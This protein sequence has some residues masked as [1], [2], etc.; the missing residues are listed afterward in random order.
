MSAFPQY[1]LVI[2]YGSLCRYDRTNGDKPFAGAPGE[3]FLHRTVDVLA[4]H[5]VPIETRV[6]G[7]PAMSLPYPTNARVLL[8]GDEA[9]A[10]ASPGDINMNKHRGYALTVQSPVTLARHAALATYHPI[11]CWDFSSADEAFSLGDA[12][13]DEDEDEDGGSESKDVAVTKRGNYFAWALHDFWKLVMRAA[14]NWNYDPLPTPSFFDGTMEEITRWLNSIPRNAVVTLDIECRPQD[15][16]LD[17]IGLRCNGRTYVLPWYFHD[18][19]LA[20]KTRAEAGAM[21]RALA[22]L[23]LRDDVTFVG[24]NLSFDF[25]VLAVELGLPLP[26]RLYDTMIAMHR[27][28]PLLEKSLSHAISYFLVTPR[29]HKADI[30]PNVSA[31]NFARLRQYNSEDLVRTEQLRAAQLASARNHPDKLL[32]IE[33]GNELLH[34]TLMMSL[35]GIPT[36]KAQIEKVR[37]EHLARADFARRC[38]A[39]LTGQPDFN[40]ASPDQVAHL[41]YDILHYPILELTK[42]NQPATGA[43]ALYKLQIEQPNPLIPLIIEHREAKKAASSLEF[44]RLRLPSLNNPVPKDETNTNPQAHAK[45]SPV[46]DI[47]FTGGLQIV[48]RA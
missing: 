19:R 6:V 11:D 38:C 29:N 2:I 30:C 33:Q 12:D 26:T 8:L 1:P 14:P 43:K 27:M 16:A 15:H 31:A 5:N 18:N 24:H 42:S 25:A 35:T 9:L 4:K 22:N 41:F 17:V 34:A 13:G 10:L 45:R 36:D 23:F 44:R 40:P 46:G 20:F 3:M 39:I 37:A 32:A 21:W 7:T 47:A 28:E 48:G